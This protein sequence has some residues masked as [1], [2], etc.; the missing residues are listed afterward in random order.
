MLHRETCVQSLMAQLQD[1]R[2]QN[3]ELQRSQQEL[4][5]AVAYTAGTSQSYGDRMTQ[6]VSTLAKF[7]A[8]SYQQD[9][10]AVAASVAEHIK[11]FN[12]HIAKCFSA[13]ETLATCY[14]AVASRIDAWNHRKKKCCFNAL[15]HTL[16]VLEMH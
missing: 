12:S 2:A 4:S 10:E 1:L 8:N 7:D 11:M 9:S 6:I 5:E 13:A 15:R 16:V 14:A 3:L